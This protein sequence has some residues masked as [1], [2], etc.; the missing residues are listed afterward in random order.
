MENAEGA[1]GALL[2]QQE[3]VCVIIEGPRGEMGSLT[4]EAGQGAEKPGCSALY[5]GSGTRL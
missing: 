2:R 4:G 5:L 1:E 3:N